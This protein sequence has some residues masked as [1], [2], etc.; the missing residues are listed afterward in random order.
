MGQARA[1]AMRHRSVGLAELRSAWKGVLSPSNAGGNNP[2]KGGALST[3]VLLHAA[4]SP[5]KA[6][7]HTFVPFPGY[8]R[9]EHHQMSPSAR[10][11]S[12]HPNLLRLPRGLLRAGGE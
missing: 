1:R 3:V 5:G 10:L 12:E 9:G 4:V 6:A 11:S 8:V 2:C 7:P